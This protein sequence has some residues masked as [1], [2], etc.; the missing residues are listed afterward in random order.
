MTIISRIK[1]GLGNQMFCY[2]MA[3]SLSL[4]SNKKLILDTETGFA[5]D[6]YKRE[7]SL[8]GYA[9]VNE[10]NT[11]L[12][13]YYKVRRKMRIL[14]FPRFNSRF[15]LSINETSLDFNSNLMNL[16]SSR[17]IYLDGYWQ[18][19]SYFIDYQ[20]IIRRDF[21]PLMEKPKHLLQME[22]RICGMNTTVFVHF[23]FFDN[24]PHTVTDNVS[25]EYYQK[26]FSKLEQIL[27]NPTYYV[28]SDKIDKVRNLF[29]IP[30][31]R[32]VKVTESYGDHLD[33]WLMSKCSHAI[34]AN[35]TFSWWA[36]W[37]I[38]NPEKIVIAP[39]YHARGVTNAWG[40][41]GLLPDKW[42][43]I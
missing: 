28:F 41:K 42:L 21:T 25:F 9:L 24:K 23:R 13:R 29:D 43:K 35:S 31:E 18:S 32:F 4:R 12:P 5:K 8:S 39:G 19:V 16:K 6:K 26:A 1:G 34:I 33:L 10:V 11:N 17:N 22:R 38:N 40:H 30:A 15:P 20:N 14:G 36:A 3:R 2:A 7:Y 27:V 37:L